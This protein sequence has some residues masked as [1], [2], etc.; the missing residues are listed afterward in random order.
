M[1]RVA[2]HFPLPPIPEKENGELRRV[3]FELEFTGLDL[4]Q[5]VAAL[6]SSLGGSAEATSA[7]EQRL[8]VDGLGTFNIELDWGYLKQVAEKNAKN[9][10]AGDW[11]ELLSQAASLLVP[12]E[13]VCP[14]IPISRLQ[15]LEPMIEAL[16]KAGAIGTRN[17][18]VAAYGV[19]VNTEIPR[20]DAPTLFAY[21]RAFG[22]LQW[23]LVKD[24][25]VDMARRISPYIDLYPQSY[26]E[27]LL[28]GSAP[29][30]D[31][32]FAD[33]LELNPTR[34]RAL[35]MLPMLAHIDRERVR[36]AL[37]DPR[38]KARPA[39]HY[40]LPDCHIEQAGWSL[41][42]AWNNWLLIERLAHLPEALDELAGAFLDSGR[43]IIG[44]SRSAWVEQMDRWL[45][46]RKL[47]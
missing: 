3:G 25:Q 45:K 24:M 26:L 41:R 17:S 42:D 28:S 47:V 29:T 23:W 7:A 10:D 13:V 46:E 20:L 5:T 34:N 36:R 4:D 33:Y 12:M 8:C 16:R 2:Q 40:R 21:L 19:H 9:G 43:P 18:P 32:L 11:V 39:F 6:E 44:I 1:N 31:Q 27:R 15:Q 30:L 37:D 35:D 38:I 14:P 22:L